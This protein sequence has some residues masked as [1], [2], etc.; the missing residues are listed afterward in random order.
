[1]VRGA[2]VRPAPGIVAGGG[3]G[4]YVGAGC[5]AYGPPNPCA[6]C[7]EWAAPQVAAGGAGVV[8]VGWAEGEEDGVVGAA[9]APAGLCYQLRLGYS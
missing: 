4:K 5:T 1:M 7:A 8:V 9:D 2:P 6:V 3:A